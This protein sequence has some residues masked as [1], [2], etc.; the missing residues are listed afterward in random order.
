MVSDP[1]LDELRHTGEEL[2][3]AFAEERRA[4]SALD[5]EALEQLAARKLELAHRLEALRGSITG[6]DPLVRDLFAAIRTEAHANALLA[7]AAANAVRE[8]L[9]YTAGGYDRHA[10][11]TTSRTGRVLATY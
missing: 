10:Q 5:R 11:T 7:S 1:V 8:L 3:A 6:E 9:G 4:I 2:R